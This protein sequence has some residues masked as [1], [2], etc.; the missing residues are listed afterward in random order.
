MT[1]ILGIDPG[2]KTTGWCLYDSETKRV[3][4]SGEFYKADKSA[5]FIRQLARPIEI[6]AN[7]DFLVVIESLEEPRASVYADTVRTAIVEGMLRERLASVGFQA[8]LLS[9]HDVKSILTAA[10]LNEVVCRKDKDVWAAIKLMHGDECHR[11]GGAI[12]GVKGHARAALAVAVAF[13]LRSEAA[14]EGP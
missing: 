14:K 2:S 5:A 6:P 7:E 13:W 4:E 8:I 3:L 9:R 12:Y 10:T 1:L 11:K